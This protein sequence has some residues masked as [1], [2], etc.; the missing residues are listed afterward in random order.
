MVSRSLRL[1]RK[2]LVISLTVFQ[3]IALS[4]CNSGDWISATWN[5]LGQWGLVSSSNPSTGKAGSTGTSGAT[6][7]SGEM[8]EE[9]FSSNAARNAKANAELLHEMFIAVNMREPK[10]RTEFGNWADTLNQ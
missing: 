8:T 5:L 10:D 2:V 4:G 1:R 6:G 7:A 3:W 9:E